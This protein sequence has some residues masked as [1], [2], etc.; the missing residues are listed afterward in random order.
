MIG[1]RLGRRRTSKDL[2]QG[3]EPGWLLQGAYLLSALLVRRK[4]R[5]AAV[6]PCR[7]PLQ[8]NCCADA[9]RD[10]ATKPGRAAARSC[11]VASRTPDRSQV[12]YHRRAGG[13]VS[14]RGRFLGANRHVVEI[15][16]KAAGEQVS[17]PVASRVTGLED[18]AVARFLGDRERPR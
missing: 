12:A 4:A 16:G 5:R 13:S 8:A 9:S 3:S 15:A 11:G 6:S 17:L 10:A 2:Q 14:E 7:M 18:T 1:M